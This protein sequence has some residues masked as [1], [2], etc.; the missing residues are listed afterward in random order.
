LPAVSTVTKAPASMRLALAAAGPSRWS[1]RQGPP[2]LDAAPPAQ[3]ARFSPE[4]RSAGLATPCGADSAAD[5]QNASVDE[6]R[7][8][9]RGVL[10]GDGSGLTFRRRCIWPRARASATVTE[11]SRSDS[12]MDAADAHPSPNDRG[13]E[14]RHPRDRSPETSG[15]GGADATATSTSR[16]EA[17]DACPP[18]D[19]W[20]GIDSTCPRSPG[21]RCSV[22][23]PWS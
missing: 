11:P 15:A 22:Q 18:R 5:H 2:D 3:V 13:E 9:I 20:K 14:S 8:G 23:P 21:S 19:P 10:N 16:A 6:V 7:G 1:R 4:E 17:T 12:S